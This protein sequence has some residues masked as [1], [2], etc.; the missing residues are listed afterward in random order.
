MANKNHGMQLRVRE[1]KSTARDKAS[2][3]QREE[4]EVHKMGIFLNVQNA[5]KVSSVLSV[6]VRMGWHGI[7]GRPCLY[8]SGRRQWPV[9]DS[10]D[11][12]L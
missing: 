9:I 5:V 7:V 6:T 2:M 10:T 12:Q 3:N 8:S 4:C 1:R 11:P